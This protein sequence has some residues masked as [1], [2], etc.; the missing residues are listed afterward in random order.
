MVEE[1]PPPRPAGLVPR[2]PAGPLDWLGSG[3][4]S[5]EPRQPG[6][7]QSG[8]GAP[9]PP[10]PL[11]GFTPLGAVAEA[12]VTELPSQVAQQ[13]AKSRSSNTCLYVDLQDQGELY[14]LVVAEVVSG[15]GQPTP[16]PSPHG[17]V[18]GPRCAMGPF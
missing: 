17:P 15:A 6:P 7:G 14:K 9:P 3:V 1:P 2:W 12:R 4:R 13:F 5:K 8:G 18:R 10:P 16:P 11:D